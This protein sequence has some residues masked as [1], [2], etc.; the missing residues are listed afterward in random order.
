MTTFLLSQRCVF[1]C[2][3]DMRL[4][5]G[6]TNSSLKCFLTAFVSMCTVGAHYGLGRPTIESTPD[7]YSK[8]MFLFLNAQLLVSVAMFTSK[9]AVAA[10]LMRIV[11]VR[12][13]APQTAFTNMKQ[14][15]SP[16]RQKWFLWFWIVTITVLG[17]FLGCTIF[18]QATP[19]QSIWDS[20]VPKQHVYLSLTVVAEVFCSKFSRSSKIQ[21]CLRGSQYG[22]PLWI[23]SSRSSRGMHFGT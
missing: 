3:E 22:R 8:G 21:A 9:I 18:T 15:D 10:F 11:V 17:I 14:A 23:S 7:Q 4:S 20:R 5:F 2:T 13:Y 19:V 16:C 6:L 12:W 1:P